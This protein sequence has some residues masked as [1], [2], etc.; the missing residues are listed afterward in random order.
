MKLRDY[1]AEVVDW[2]E[3]VVVRQGRNSAFVQAPAG[4]GKTIIAA[5]AVARIV[6]PGQTVGWLA[7]TREQVD[8]AIKAIESVEGP[9]GVS[10]KVGC[11]A[12]QPDVSEVDILIVDESHHAPAR[13]W[14]ATIQP[15][16]DGGAIVWGF[17]ATPWSGDEERDDLLRSTFVA[18]R[19]IGRGRVQDSGHLAPGKVYVYDLDEAGQFDDEI[20][21]KTRIEV[22]RRTRSFPMVLQWEHERRAKWQFTQ[23][24]VQNNGIRNGKVATLARQ[25]S[26]AGHSTLVLVGSIEHG[27]RL[28]EAIG[29][30]SAVV[31]SKLSSRQRKDLIDSFRDGSRRVLV[32]TSLADEG[33]D[34]PRA[35]HLILVAGGRSS[36]KLEQRAGR[37]LRPFPGKAGGVIFDFLD[38]G[39]TFAFAQAQSRIE[40]FTKLGYNPEIVTR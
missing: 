37:V 30:S 10:F 29:P 18:F 9:E 21:E 34:I 20:N 27:E 39:A 8:Q 36:G 25:C 13:T 31:H 12:G 1:Q 3:D 5:A 14:A 19:T 17:S 7:N 40:T 28:V 26:E 35:S 4:S 15:A 23:E 32:A 11:V 6:K 22:L 33:L 16:L 24:A 2:L 38:R